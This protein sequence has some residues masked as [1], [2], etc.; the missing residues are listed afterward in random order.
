MKKK[1]NGPSAEMK[2]AQWEELALPWSSKH[3]RGFV[4][5][6]HACALS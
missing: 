5:W 2:D 3:V 4:E 6:L 1:D